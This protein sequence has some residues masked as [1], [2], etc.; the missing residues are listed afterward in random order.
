MLDKEKL[1]AVKRIPI[2]QY[3]LEV[4]PEI[5]P[6]LAGVDLDLYSRP[7]CCCPVH[8]EKTP[9]FRW[10]EDTNTC[11][12]FG[13]GAGGDIINLHRKILSVNEEVEVSFDEAAEHL[14]ELFIGDSDCS[15][16]LNVPKAG[17]KTKKEL[18]VYEHTVLNRASKKNYGLVEDLHLLIRLSS[19]DSVYTQGA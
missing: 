1:D 4:V 8:N 9:S 5:A 12:C 15:S 14:Y 18:L 10:F 16:L 13:C 6:S 2:P 7:V 17:E 11:Y 19:V 3:L